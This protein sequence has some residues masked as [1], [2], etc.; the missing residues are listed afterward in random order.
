ML[1]NIIKLLLPVFLMV[2]CRA[3][4]PT[5]NAVDTIEFGYGGGFSGLYK[6]HVID[7]RQHTIMKSGGESRRLNKKEIRT[8]H[9]ELGKE[10]FL[11]VSLDRPHNM[12]TYIQLKGEV[13]NRITWGD[14][15]AEVPEE[16]ENLYNFLVSLTDIL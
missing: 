11:S 15:S 3:S 4:V 8:L 14:P 6:Y 12:S 7:L 10:N 13:S 5:T 1:I 2:S 9:K 16:V